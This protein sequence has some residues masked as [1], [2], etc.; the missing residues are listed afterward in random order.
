MYTVIE[1]YLNNFEVAKKPYTLCMVVDR[2]HSFFQPELSM[3]ILVTYTLKQSVLLHNK[4]RTICMH[5]QFDNQLQ[6]S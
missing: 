5:K 3:V 2:P 6:K 1:S 4:T